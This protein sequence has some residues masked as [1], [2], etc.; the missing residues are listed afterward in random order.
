MV[1]LGGD[2]NFD[3]RIAMH[4]DHSSARETFKQPIL[5]WTP[6]DNRALVWDSATMSNPQLVIP[7][8]RIS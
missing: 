7:Y 4:L 1:G 2:N 6:Q 8:S 3:I 5:R